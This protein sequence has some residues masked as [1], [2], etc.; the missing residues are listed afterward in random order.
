MTQDITLLTEEEENEFLNSVVMS[1]CPEC[2]NAVYQNPRGRKKKF[3]CDAC[4]I[5]WKNKHPKPQ[6]WKSARIAFCPLCGKK[7]IASREYLQKRR[8]CSHACANRGRALVKKGLL[9][10]TENRPEEENEGH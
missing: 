2:G 10:I 6:N 8:Y 5:A 9:E 1:F 4:R 3:C 7:F